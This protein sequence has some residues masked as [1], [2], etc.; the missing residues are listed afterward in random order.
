VNTDVIDKDKIESSP[1]V[2]NE[3][4]FDKFADSYKECVNSTLGL[5]GEDADYF[6]AGRVDWLRRALADRDDLRNLMDYGCGIG[7]GT[8]HLLTFPGIQSLIGV[9]I[10]ERSLERARRD[11]GSDQVKFA[12]FDE[13]QP[14]GEIDMAVCCSVF[15]HIPLEGRADAVRNIYDSLRP[16]GLL[17]LWE[18]NPWNPAVVHVMNHSPLDQDAIKVKPHQA[19]RLLREGGFSIVRTDYVFFFPAFLK[20]FRGLE[21]YL[22]WLPMGGQ[23]LVLARKDR[24]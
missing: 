14:K 3:Q 5:A 11:H 7:V 21:P 13:Y 19:R 15:H 1:G 16:G 23:Y 17:A 2:E 12:S 8:P 22:S 20:I 10:S 6:A 4:E 24:P 9:D 18:H